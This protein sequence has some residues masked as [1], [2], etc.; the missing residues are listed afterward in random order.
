MAGKNTKYKPGQVRRIAINRIRVHRANLPATCPEIMPEEELRER[1][2]RYGKTRSKLYQDIEPITVKYVP[3]YSTRQ[4][5]LVGGGESYLRAQKLGVDTIL[6]TIVA[7]NEEPT[8][9]ISSWFDM[10]D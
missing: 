5:I 10:G 3:K 2:H 8:C 6:C 1:A 4:F 7:E 9:D